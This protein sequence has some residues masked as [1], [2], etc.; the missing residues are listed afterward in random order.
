MLSTVYKQTYIYIDRKMR[1][2]Q[3]RWKTEKKEKKREKERFGSL[4]IG[5][6]LRFG[7]HYELSD[8]RC[9]N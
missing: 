6:H 8:L 2:G 3:H 4:R 5:S 9:I 7:L 1:C